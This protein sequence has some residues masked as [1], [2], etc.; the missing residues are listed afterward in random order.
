MASFLLP[1]HTGQTCGV[2]G[3]LLSHAHSLYHK[4]MYSSSFKVAIGLLVASLISLLLTWSSSLEGRP[5]LG[6]VL[7]VPYAFHFLMIV[8]TVLQ[9]IFKAF[10]IFYTHPL[11]CAFPQLYPRGLLKAPW[12]SWLSL[13]CEM[14]YPAEG[15]HRK[16][17]FYSEIIIITITI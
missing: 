1:Y 5:D 11:I 2:L 7:V 4:G 3:I 16:S 17:W 12:C 6:R 15:T 8:L 10:Y 14:H 9:G 13:C